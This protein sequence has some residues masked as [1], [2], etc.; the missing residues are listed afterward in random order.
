MT[1]HL[2]CVILFLYLAVPVTLALRQWP[3]QWSA[4]QY[5]HKFVASICASSLL[6]TPLIPLPVLAAGNPALEA[7]TRAMLEKKEKTTT[8]RNFDGLPEAG[9]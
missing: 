3:T 4:A 2:I 7:A 1:F 6:L 9:E 8:E 5:K